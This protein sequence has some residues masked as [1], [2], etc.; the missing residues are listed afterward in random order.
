MK[1]QLI[2]N[3]DINDFCDYIGS[4]ILFIDF[5]FYEVPFMK[6]MVV[7]DEPDIQMLFEQQF[8]KE[9]KSDKVKFHFALSA[10]SALEYLKE[11]TNSDLRLIFSDINMPGMNGIELLK[12]VKTNYPDL[13]IYMITAYGDEKSRQ[14]AIKLGCDDYLSKP[15]DF[16]DLRNRIFS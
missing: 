8:R 2:L 15:I 4:Y 10:E 11:K 3:T 6:I 1:P 12:Q 16:D 7:D 5:N 9:I 14:Q 13:S